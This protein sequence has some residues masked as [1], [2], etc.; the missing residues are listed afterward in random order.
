[1]SLNTCNV[2][3]CTLFDIDD[4]SLIYKFSVINLINLFD[5]DGEALI[6]ACSF[7]FENLMMTLWF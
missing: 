6:L 1:M 2:C 5:D 7:V 4:V 3:K